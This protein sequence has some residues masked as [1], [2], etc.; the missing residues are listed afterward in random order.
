MMM[1]NTK[2]IYC[3]QLQP[4]ILIKCIHSFFHVKKTKKLMPE[5]LQILTETATQYVTYIPRRSRTVQKWLLQNILLAN[6]DSA[7]K[8]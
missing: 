6:I 3:I 7:L 5:M 8:L 1:Y 4:R 2:D